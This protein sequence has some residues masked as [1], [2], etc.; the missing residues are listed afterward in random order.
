M[1][2]ILAHENQIFYLF[3]YRVAAMDAYN[4]IVILIVYDVMYCSIFCHLG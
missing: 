4:K 2:V 1:S 3:I